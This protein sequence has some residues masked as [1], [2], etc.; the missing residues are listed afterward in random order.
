MR[1]IRLVTALAL[2]A[3]AVN[4]PPAT[5]VSAQGQAQEPGQRLTGRT[6]SR[7]NSVY[8]VQMVEPPAGSYVGGIAGLPATKAPRGAKLDPNN[9]AVV[10]YGAF[11]QGRHDQA[12]A[13]SGGRKLY[14]YRYSFN[15]F[16]AELTEAWERVQRVAAARGLDEAVVRDLVARHTEGRQ[17]GFL[18]EPRVNVLQLNLALDELH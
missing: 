6:A 1:R 18:G 14:D 17:F 5:R 9:P 11:L 3:F 4:P 2:V 16:A 13:R 15:G 8:I 12:L 10:S 7:N